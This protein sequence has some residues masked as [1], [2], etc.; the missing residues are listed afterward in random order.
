[1]FSQN[2]LELKPSFRVAIV[3]SV[4]CIASLILIISAQIPV[5]ISFI[6]I[7]IHLYL[8]YKFVARTAL[9]TSPASIQS[10][11]IDNQTI[12]LD[13]K[14][15]RRFIARPLEKNIL[16][17]TFSLLSFE[18]DQLNSVPVH[19]KPVEVDANFEQVNT[20]EFF[21]TK[22]FNDSSNHT[23]KSILVSIRALLNTKILSKN[24]R[25]VFI[26]RYNAV[27]LNA[28]RRARVWFKFKL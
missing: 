3:L 22:Q 14:S 26:C 8:S 1:M 9:L 25:H 13:D 20:T 6:L 19:S 27:D 5:F 15:G 16:H 10:L 18:C 4:P 12:Y 24:R 23:F 28:F 21:S 11:Q 2:R 7:C 17:P